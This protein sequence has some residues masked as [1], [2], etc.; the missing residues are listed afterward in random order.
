MRKHWQLLTIVLFSIFFGLG[1]SGSDENYPE[2]I[3]AEMRQ[4]YERGKAYYKLG[5]YDKSVKEFQ[6]A[7]ELSNKL[8]AQ[9]KKEPLPVKGDKS[10]YL[11]DIGDVLDIS[12]WKVPDLSQ[13]EVIVRPDGKI[14]LPLIGDLSASGMSLTSLDENITKRYSEYVRQ[15]QVSVMIRRFGGKKVVILGEVAKPGVYSFS[16]DIR[17]MEAIALAGDCTKYAV[18]KNILVIRGDI[19]NKPQVVSANMLAVIKKANMAE[20]LAIQAQDI[21]F[22]PRAVIGNINTFLESIAP[23]INAYFTGQNIRM[24]NRAASQN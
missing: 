12:V 7:I 9:E 6:K 19:N 1:L 13:S 3:N 16:T 21:I 23:V 10:E 2:G 11:I 20:N 18:K 4:F 17:L 24:M 15:P 5:D 22:V 8:S 14:S